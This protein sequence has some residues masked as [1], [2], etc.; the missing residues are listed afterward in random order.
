MILEACN[1]A[2]N[3]S[4]SVDFKEGRKG[5]AMHDVNVSFEHS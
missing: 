4:K 5:V 2:V 3:V 1:V